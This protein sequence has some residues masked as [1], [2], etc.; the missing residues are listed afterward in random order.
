M[1]QNIFTIYLLE[2]NWVQS[3]PM[4]FV[5]SN[6]PELEIF[7]DTSSQIEIYYQGKRIGD[8]YLLELNDLENALRSLTSK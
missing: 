6:N 5:N 2:R 3:A 4:T 1:F 8:Y 7:F